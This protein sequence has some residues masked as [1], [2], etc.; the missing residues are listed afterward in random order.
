MNPHLPPAPRFRSREG[1]QLLRDPLAFYL[2]LAQQYGD[3]VC[4]RPAPELAFLVNHPDHIRHVLVENHHNYSKDTYIN[5]MFKTMVGDGLITSEGEAWRRQRRLMQPAFHPQRLAALDALITSQVAAM[6]ARWGVASAQAQP[7]NLAHEISALTLSITT[8]ALFGVDLGEDVSLVGQAV[9]MGGAL[10][11]RPRDPRF[12]QGLQVVDEIVQ[13]IILSRRAEGVLAG[14]TSP[15]G[16]LLGAMMS[17]RDAHTGLGMDDSSLRDQVITLLLAG[18]ETTASALAWTFYLLSQNPDV[19]GRLR[20]ELSASLGGRPPVY[21]DLPR[22]PYTRQVFEESLRLY[23]PAWVL[24]R[25]ALEDDMLGEY[26]LPAGTVVAISPYTAHRRPAAWDHPERFTPGRPQPQRF[27][28]LPF[29]AG[30]RQCIGKPF[31]MMEAQLIIAMVVQR[32]DL[33][34]VP[35]H[36]I[37]PEVVF[38]LRPDRQMKVTLA[39]PAS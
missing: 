22:L 24:G 15:G 5:H 26:T 36:E 17:L 14:G 13:R 20:L 10:L 11:A 3:L 39:P 18:Y 16:D 30:P 32:F 29:G 2:A 7:V 6:L 38:V 19:V 37:K 9:D 23:P 1:R 28:Y 34:L 35:D 27:A 31:A 33:T 25:V 12:R 21:A 8:Q 4:Y